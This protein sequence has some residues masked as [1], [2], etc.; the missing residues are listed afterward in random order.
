[1]G[2]CRHQ[3]SRSAIK[4]QLSAHLDL[5][6]SQINLVYLRKRWLTWCTR[7]VSAER[8]NSDSDN[9]DDNDN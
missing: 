9:D 2:S 1:M 7:S 3:R 8:P 5:R 6:Y 4:E